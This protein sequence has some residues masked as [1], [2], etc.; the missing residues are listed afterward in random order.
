[1]V[2]IPAGDITN[3]HY[4]FV[5]A[6]PLVCNKVILLSGHCMKELRGGWG[7]EG[8]EGGNRIGSVVKR[9]NRGER[10]NSLITSHFS[11][12]VLSSDHS[13]LRIYTYTQSH[14]SQADKYL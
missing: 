2:P 3:S 11:V 6:K 1:M 14:T 10:G 13:C 5:V 9:V 8:R 4:N 7:L 12:L